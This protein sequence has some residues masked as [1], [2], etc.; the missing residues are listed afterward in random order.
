MEPAAVSAEN[1]PPILRSDKAELATR[2]SVN[3]GAR[4]ARFARALIAF[5]AGR[6]RT[7]GASATLMLSVLFL[8]YLV[9]VHHIFWDFR[10]YLAGLKAYRAIGTP[11]NAS[12]LASAYNSQFPFTYAPIVLLVFDQLRWLF[13]TRTGLVLLCVLHLAASIAVPL[14]LMPPRYRPPS[15]DFG[16]FFGAYL[17]AFGFWGLKLFA[18]GNIE[19]ILMCALLLALMASI[20]RG[21]Y[22]LFWIA[23]VLACQVKIYFICLAAVPLLLDRKIWQ[24]VVACALALAAYL[25]NYATAPQLVAGFTSTLA[26]IAQDP[27]YTGDTVM[28]AVQ[29]AL[30]RVHLVAHGLVL[31]IALAVHAVY[32]A[33]LLAFAIAVMWSDARPADSHSALLWSFTG[34]MLLSPRLIEGDLAILVVPALALIAAMVER[35]GVGLLILLVGLIAGSSMV[36]IRYAEWEGLIILTAVWIGYGLD[37][38]SGAGLA[39]GPL[40]PV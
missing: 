40:K 37:R 4:L 8:L 11:Y 32:A 23:L 28:S 22:L 24:P 6:W 3:L 36:K 31:P 21:N 15:R 27:G 5:A 17:V 13:E 29:I 35:R 20:K 25:I 10:V 9:A 33:A 16:W 26:R 14:L 39:R 38:L 19:A 34:A 12:D 18:S 7:I 30:G 2:W 1:G